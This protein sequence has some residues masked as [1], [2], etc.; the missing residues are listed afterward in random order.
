MEKSYS[1][2]SVSKNCSRNGEHLTVINE[3]LVERPKCIHGPTLLFEKTF[4]NGTQPTQFYACSAV[5]NPNECPILSDEQVVLNR[6]QLEA[7]SESVIG[8]AEVNNVFIFSF[9]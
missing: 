2:H 9:L 6:A 5:R 7:H 4:D 8:L 1:V 3:N